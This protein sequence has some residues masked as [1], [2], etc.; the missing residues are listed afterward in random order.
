MFLGDTCMPR[1]VG[2]EQP[3]WSVVGL[4]FFLVR[5]K[6]GRV[7]RPQ[8]IHALS[9]TNLRGYGLMEAA[10]ESANS[11][12]RRLKKLAQI[13]TATRVGCPF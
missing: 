6:L 2:V 5:R 9:P 7:V 3:G 8:R 10:Q 4:I 1:L 13:R 11:V 12:P